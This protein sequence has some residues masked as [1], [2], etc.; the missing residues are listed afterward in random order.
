MS[1]EP[2][3]PLSVVREILAMQNE[4][5][6]RVAQMMGEHLE[7]TAALY[8]RALNPPVVPITSPPV[9]NDWRMDEAE[10]DARYQFDNQQITQEQLNT[11]L[12]D[13][14]KSQNVGFDLG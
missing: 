7:K 10:E 3:V 12:E 13:I 2:K 8:E 1:R 5:M 6:T 4:H 14:A 9:T 11:V